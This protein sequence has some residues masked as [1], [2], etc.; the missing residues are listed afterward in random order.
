MTICQCPHS[1]D[2]PLAAPQHDD[3]GCL[4]ESPRIDATLSYVARKPSKRSSMSRT[5]HKV[6]AP[7]RDASANSAPAA[8]RGCERECCEAEPRRSFSCRAPQ[9]CTAPC[10]GSLLPLRGASGGPPFPEPRIVLRERF[11]TARLPSSLSAVY[12]LLLSPKANRPT[13]DTSF[14]PS[15]TMCVVPPRLAS[16]GLHLHRHVVLARVVPFFRPT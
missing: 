8:S 1:E 4:Q 6:R 2:G 13:I 9:L 7:G 10:F 3:A 5:R 16:C 11:W 12:F 15:K 14:G